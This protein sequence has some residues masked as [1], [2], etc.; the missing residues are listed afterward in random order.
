MR[1][2]HK[3]NE[4]VTA[5]AAVISWHKCDICKNETYAIYILQLDKWYCASCIEKVCELIEDIA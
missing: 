4:T 1:E 2:G 5:D 3:V